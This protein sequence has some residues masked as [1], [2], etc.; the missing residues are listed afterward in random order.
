MSGSPRPS[1]G[2]GTDGGG[3][4]VQYTALHPI[5]FDILYSY[6]TLT[7]KPHN[8]V[9]SAPAGA[10]RLCARRKA[11]CEMRFQFRLISVPTPRAIGSLPPGGGATLRTL[12]LLG[13]GGV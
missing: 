11:F 4:L 5:L 1:W 13:G 8:Q 3:A 6:K 9:F 2:G 10:A 7:R 12:T